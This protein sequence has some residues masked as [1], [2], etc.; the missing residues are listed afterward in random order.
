MPCSGGEGDEFQLKGEV[1]VGRV[2]DCEV[3]GC[4][5]MLLELLVRYDDEKRVGVSVPGT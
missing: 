5:V 1:G 3:E 2:A 4:E